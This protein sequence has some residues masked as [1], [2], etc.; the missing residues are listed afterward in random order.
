MKEK[1]ESQIETMIFNQHVM[2]DSIAKV[3]QDVVD[4]N[5]E[6][7]DLKDMLQNEMISIKNMIMDLSLKNQDRDSMVES[8]M[9]GQSSDRGKEEGDAVSKNS[10]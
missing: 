5:E 4:V 6:V 7:Q 9:S 3:S 8:I 1:D 2:K 10:D